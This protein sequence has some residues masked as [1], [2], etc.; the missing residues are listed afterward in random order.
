MCVYVFTLFGCLV[1]EF[2]LD[3]GGFTPLGKTVQA[4]RS[5]KV[6]SAALSERTHIN[7]ILLTCSHYALMP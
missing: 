5:D 1:S 2:S 3:R 7:T 6:T 4:E